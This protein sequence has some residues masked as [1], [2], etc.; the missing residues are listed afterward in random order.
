MAEKPESKPLT[1]ETVKVCYVR[2]GKR[3][4]KEI[5]Q[6]VVFV[7][8]GCNFC[9]MTLGHLQARGVKVKQIPVVNKKTFDKMREVSGQEQTPVTVIGN[10]VIVG[11]APKAIDRVLGIK[12]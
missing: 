1:T 6:P 4:C 11:Y 5:P 2:N 7:Q 10:R 8:K 9:S 3:G 12:R